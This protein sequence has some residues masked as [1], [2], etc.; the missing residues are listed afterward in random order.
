M[1]SNVAAE[2]EAIVGAYPRTSHETSTKDLKARTLRGGVAKVGAQAAGFVMRIGSLMILARVLDPKDFG[3]VGMVTVVTGVFSLFKDAG[4]SMVTVQ[5]ATITDEQVSTLFWINMLVGAGLAVLSVAIAPALV[6]FYREPRLLWVTTVLATGFVF[7]AAGVQHSALLQRQMRFG[8]L[9]AIDVVSLIASLAVA[10]G[11]ALGGY[12]YWA[13]VA[14]AVTLPAVSTVC[15]WLMAAWIPGAPRRRTGMRSMM[16]FGSAITLNSLIV[17][18]AYNMD[19]VLLGRLWG[20]EVLGIYGRAYQLINIPTENLNSAVGGVAVSALSRLQ[21]DPNRFK[22]YFLKGYSLVL[23]LT[24]PL[25]VA[26]GLFAHDIILVLL[27]PK[28]MSAVPI[29]RFLAPTILAFALINPLAWLLFSSGHVGR[30]LK[31]ALVIAPL[32]VLSYVAGLPYGSS[33]VAFGYSTMMTLLVVPMIVWATHETIISW[34]DVLR[35][36]KPPAISAA[37]ATAVTLA[38]HYAWIHGLSP[39]P[40]LMAECSVLGGLYGV[41]LLAD[42]DQRTSY[43]DLARDLRGR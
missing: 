43:L 14:M 2:S 24:I 38:I 9:A 32:V 1:I 13:L 40:R 23:V 27:G 15:A 17:Y 28:W 3:L 25:T 19:K 12:G 34:R 5:R 8:A 20:A 16:R 33:G 31:M 7:N 18:V 41:M 6:V 30:S 35:A 4:L 22:S 21:G 36:V 10:I 37:V 42:R 29:F 39:L 26:C 11:M